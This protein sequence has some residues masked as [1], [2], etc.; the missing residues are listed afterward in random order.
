M[1][2]HKTIFITGGGS[3][4]GRAIAIRFAHAGWFVGLGDVSEAGMAET[5]RL[6]PG[7]YVYSHVFDVSDRAAWDEALRIV[8]VAAGGRIDV[9]ANNAGISLG[10]LP[11]VAPANVLV[12]G[13]GVVGHNAAKVAAG[14]GANVTLMD[15]NLERL[16]Y[17]DDVMAANVTTVFS[18]PLSV[19][20]YLKDADLVIGAVLIPGAR[21]PRLVTRDDLK[22]MKNGSVIVDVAIDQGG[23]IETSRPTTHR[24]PTFIVDGVVHTGFEYDT[25]RTFLAAHP[26]N[27]L[28]S[29][30]IVLVLSGIAYKV[31]AFPFQIW[32]PDV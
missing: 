24:D 5:E 1:A 28:A 31:A 26:H 9:V 23:C 21:A 11:G 12:L 8:S 22:D 27:F 4:I 6:M 13:A 19:R 2:T 29:V 17:L 18:D 14:L 30:G 25:L 10:G 7:G 32:V 16:R 20:Q 15:I 3:G